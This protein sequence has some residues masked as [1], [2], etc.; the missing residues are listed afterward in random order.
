MMCLLNAAGNSASSASNKYSNYD[1][2]DSPPSSEISDSSKSP[3]QLSP[4][5]PIFVDLS[6]KNAS[7]TL[8]LSPQM[9]LLTPQIK[10]VSGS[11]TP[12]PEETFLNLKTVPFTF[13]NMKQNIFDLPKKKKKRKGGPGRK[14]KQISNQPIETAIDTNL[15][16]KIESPE[17]EFLCSKSN[18]TDFENNFE[19]EFED[20]IVNASDFSEEDLDSEFNDSKE[21]V[22]DVVNNLLSSIFDPP[23]S[24]YK[25]IPELPSVP[26]TDLFA[27]TPLSSF[28]CCGCSKKYSN[29]DTFSVDLKC[30]TILLTCSTCQW[31]SNRRI[32]FDPVF[33]AQ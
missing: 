23:K 19:S 21:I 15:K 20:E 11:I 24:P 31:W 26:L 29:Q 33:A 18:K 1:S 2:M 10:E 3:P 22:E 17:P 13:C 16:R 30:Q 7:E 6:V 5:D 4:Q 8:L 14:P 27:K 25:I 12:E 32:H 9:A 28:F